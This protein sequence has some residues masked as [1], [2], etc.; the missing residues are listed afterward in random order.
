MPTPP[1]WTPTPA[2]PAAGWRAANVASRR[3]PGT[4]MPRQFGPTSRMP[5]RR[6]QSSSAPVAARSSPELIT[7]SAP[8]PRSP[9][10]SAIRSTAAAGTASTARSTGPGSAAGDGTHGT[11]SISEACGFTACTRPP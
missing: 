1:D 4:A 8:T 10:S 2:M 7:T 3:M 11:P 5:W 6:Q 9:H